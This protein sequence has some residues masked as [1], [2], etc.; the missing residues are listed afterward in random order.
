MVLGLPLCKHDMLEHVLRAGTICETEAIDWT[1]KLC[2]AVQHLHSRNV[3]HLDVK[4]ENIFIDAEG[5]L[6]LGDMGLAAFSQPG[7]TLAK[8][9]GSGV[10]AAPE[11]LGA[12]EFGPYDGFAADVW[13]IGVCSFT[14]VRG[15]FPFSMD[16]PLRTYAAWRAAT[17]LARLNNDGALPPQPLILNSEVQRKYFSSSHLELLDACLNLNPVMRPSAQDLLRLSWL[18]PKSGTPTPGRTEPYLCPVTPESSTRAT[19]C[20]STPFPPTFA[21]AV[22]HTTPETVRWKRRVQPVQAKALSSD[23][24]PPPFITSVVKPPSS[25]LT[26]HMRAVRPERKPEDVLKRPRALLAAPPCKAQRTT[27]IN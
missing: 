12:N 26:A 5:D 14:L 24:K 6:K 2:G 23:A 10:Y 4:L 25:F 11:V 20:P 21:E 8:Q 18:A 13:S 19:P 9:C 7:H 17:D 22:V 1:T 3:V 27:T 16:V 15:R